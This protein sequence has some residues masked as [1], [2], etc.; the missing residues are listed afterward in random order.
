MKIYF[1]RHGESVGNRKGLY[2][3]YDMPLSDTGL[4]QAKRV[5][6]RLKNHKINVIYSS[7]HERARQTAVVIS[8]TLNIPVEYWADLIEIRNP[9]E[10]IGKSIHDLKT[11]QIKDLLTENFAKGNWKYSDEETFNE[12]NIRVEKIVNHL[13]Q[14]H[15]GQN[16]ICVSHGTAIKAVIF[17]MV[18]G[19][20]LTPELFSKIRFHFWSTNTGISVCEYIKGRGWGI[21]SWNDSSH[22]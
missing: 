20:K 11:K 16:V 12:L 13:L 10:I 21:T 4:S 3:T 9:S 8:K 17:K 19:N 1:V 2:Q 15:K 7:T 18:F 6:K 14:K 22:L 5:A